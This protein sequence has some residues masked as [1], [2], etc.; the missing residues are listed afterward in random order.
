MNAFASVISK[1]RSMA[2]S[3]QDALIGALP[4]EQSRAGK[5]LHVAKGVFVAAAPYII[6]LSPWHVFYGMPIKILAVTATLLNITYERQK[7]KSHPRSSLTTATS[8]ALVATH[9]L[10]LA[11]LMGCI[12]CTLRCRIAADSVFLLGAGI[13]S[14]RAMVEGVRQIAVGLKTEGMSRT[15]K[16]VHCV[17]GTLLTTLGAL[18]LR[19]NYQTAM[20]V[21]SGI[22]KFSTWDPKQ[23]KEILRHR[24]LHT[25]SDEKRC[26]A[27]V[28]DGLESGPSEG[29]ASFLTEQ[30]Y[31]NCA[32]RTYRV[33]SNDMFCRALQ[34]AESSFGGKIDLLSTYGHASPL[35]QNL[36]DEYHF[37]GDEPELLE[38]LN[39]HLAKDAQIVVAGCNTATINPC[40][41]YTLIEKVA[42]GV[43]GREV[44]GF[45]SYLNPTLVYSY[46]KDKIYIEHFYPASSNG[47]ELEQSAVTTRAL[48][49]GVL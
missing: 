18:S 6:V 9:I 39:K 2:T 30:I 4:S 8:M 46:F 15:D 14:G 36:G 42:Q 16:V 34:E 10:G 26:N 22:E 29:G 40:Y 28:I 44:I 11:D 33:S 35:F 23:Q 13:G 12:P 1:G 41:R 37:F 5:V 48:G 49:E 32:T 31:K 19:A 3:V 25:L 47:I 17:S 7:I 24:A 21:A 38:C 20:K 27:V 43:P 45:K